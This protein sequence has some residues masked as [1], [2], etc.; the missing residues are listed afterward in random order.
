VREES[1]EQ[2]KVEQRLNRFTFPLVHIDGVAERGER[3]KGDARGQNDIGFG[4]MIIESQCI[5]QRYEIVEQKCA[6]LEKTK[7]A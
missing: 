6:V 1:D 2:R 7:H 3:I 5:D 4:R